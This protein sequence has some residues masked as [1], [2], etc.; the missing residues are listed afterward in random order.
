MYKTITIHTRSTYWTNREANIEELIVDSD[1]LAHE[2][3]KVSNELNDEGFEIVCI[4]PINSGTVSN[5]NG[6]YQTESVIIT[7][8][9]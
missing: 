9:K 2:I 5:G 8:K 3:A 6:Y 4:T 7:A 1:D